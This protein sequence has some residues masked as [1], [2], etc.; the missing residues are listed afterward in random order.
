MKLEDARLKRHV[1]SLI[2]L[3]NYFLFSPFSAHSFSQ[4]ALNVYPGCA[5]IPYMKILNLLSFAYIYI[6][7]QTFKRKSRHSGDLQM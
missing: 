2:W 7:M 3:Y 5:E 6:E 1:A 4:D